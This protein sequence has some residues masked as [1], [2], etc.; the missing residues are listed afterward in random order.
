[1]QLDL[2]GGSM[3]PRSLPPESFAVM[4]RIVGAAGLFSAP[5]SLTGSL[6][7]GWM[8]TLCSQI[9]STSLYF[10]L[11]DSLKHVFLP[12]DNTAMKSNTG[13]L[14]LLKFAFADCSV[15]LQQFTSQKFNKSASGLSE[16]IFINFSLQISII[17]GNFSEAVHLQ[18]VASNLP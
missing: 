3:G 17:I 8:A 14:V 11:F 7:R 5:F 13:Q 4:R 12:H 1:M 9:I 15:C 10:G 16:A 18:K 6:Y 2:G